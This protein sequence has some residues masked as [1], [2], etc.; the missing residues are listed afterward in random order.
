MSAHDPAAA[1]YPVL[2]VTVPDGPLAVHDLTGAGPA[3]AADLSA[4]GTGPVVL[5]MHGITANGLSWAAVAQEVC[6]RHPDVRFLAPDIRGRAE[7]RQV[8]PPYGISLDAEDALAVAAQVGRP[9]LLIG[10]SMGAFVAAT[11]TAADPE[12]VR[13]LVL[14]DGGLA[15]P[16]PPGADIDAVLL[17]LIGPSMTRLDMRFDGPEE[18]LEFWE[19][20]PAMGPLL[21]GEY[22]A[23]V[24]GYLQHDLR[25]LPDEPGRYGSSCQ[26]DAIRADGSDLLF[27]AEVLAA[28]ARAVAAGVPT[29]LLWADRGLLDEPQGIYDPARLASL[30]LPAAL[31]VT[32]VP[33]TNHFSII[34][35]PAGVSAVA[36]AVD[37]VF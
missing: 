18:Y 10:H 35:A 28:P 12:A 8:G 4:G 13:G 23:A 16:A 22:G 5:A 9:V 14:V 21:D 29:E 3:P 2:H 37:R 31:R 6:R 26:R 19:P 27:D 32:R 25:P 17:A 34:L 7:S 24:R 1:S 15:V 33:D 30:N 11:A 20:H 36:D